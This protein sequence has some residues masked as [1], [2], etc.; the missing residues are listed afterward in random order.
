MKL[1]LSGTDRPGSNSRKV[2]DIIAK[3]LLELGEAN[4]ILDLAEIQLV[5]R[6]QK[7]HYGKPA[8]APIQKYLD[9][10]NQCEGLIVVCPEYNGS[11]PGILKWFI[12]HLKYPDAF[13]ARPVSFVGLGGMFGGLRAVEHLQQVFGYRNSYIFPERVFLT[14]IFKTL[15]DGELTDAVAM[16]LLKKQVSGFCRFC[17]AL[18]G[19]GLDAL[20][21]QKKKA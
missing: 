14:N 15:K 11:M 18:Q 12:D 7:S 9:Q 2:S 20:S 21:L 10:I 3:L 6:M 19:E 1:I 17:R 5:E 13:E 8:P 16:E 4:E